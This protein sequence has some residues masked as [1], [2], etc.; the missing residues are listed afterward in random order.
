MSKKTKKKK[1]EKIAD[2][3]NNLIRRIE[4]R[5]RRELTPKEM[6]V[7][8]KIAEEK[9]EKK[10]RRRRAILGILAAIGIGS[11]AVA[12]LNSAEK[13]EAQPEQIGQETENID[14]KDNKE[15]K[16][17]REKYLEELRESVDTENG[18]NETEENL[19]KVIDEIL[20]EYN[21]NL[22]EEQ[23]IKQEDLGVINQASGSI[24]QIT[25]D[26]SGKYV[27]APITADESKEYVDE[28]VKDGYY[29]VNN[30]GNETVAG[31]IRTKDGYYEIQ[32]DYASIT[33]GDNGRDTYTRNPD[34][35]VNLEELF[36]E[37]LESGEINWETIGESFE[38]YYQ[39][40]LQN[41][42]NTKEDEGLEH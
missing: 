29:L 23:K 41:L 5:K 17:D 21:A 3:A 9:V 1:E 12:L 18:I 15:I 2:Y 4:K 27:K 37:Q 33:D 22:P 19:D 14:E 35:Y 20:E 28:E 11:R 34:T 24:G 26:S 13:A 36:S 38:E 30:H 42:Q 25:K 16:T 6:E 40:R 10:E 8:F 31:M 39:E 7:A 32:V